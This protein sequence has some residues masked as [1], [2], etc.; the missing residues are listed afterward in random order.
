MAC[1]GDRT[2]IRPKRDAAQDV[3]ERAL[4]AAVRARDA[5]DLPR[6]DVKRDIIDG[7]E[8]AEGFSET[9]GG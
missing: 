1:K 2:T 5:E 7:L 6:H 4:A 3:E 8:R 9:F